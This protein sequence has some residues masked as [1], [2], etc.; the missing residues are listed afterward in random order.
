MA[1]SRRV[2]LIATI[3]FVVA[4]RTESTQ[5]Q[6]AIDRE[7][8]QALERTLVEVIARVEPSVVAISRAKPVPAQAGRQ[9]PLRLR[10]NAQGVPEPVP[11]G[12]CHLIHWRQYAG[13]RRPC[14]PMLTGQAS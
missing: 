5:A 1:A 14:R 11:P 4:G 8:A 3:F 12:P 10:I 6:A 13:H 9:K 7:A 2:I